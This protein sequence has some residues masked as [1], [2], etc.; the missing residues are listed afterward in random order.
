MNRQPPCSDEDL[1]R[2]VDEELSDGERARM[3]DLLERNPQVADRVQ[4]HRMV[5]DLVRQAFEEIETAARPLAPEHRRHTIPRIAAAAALFVPLGFLAGWLA[6]P[7]LPDRGEPTLL[8]GGVSLE[9]TSGRLTHALFHIDA[10]DPAAMEKLLERAESILARS[11]DADAQ[12]EVVANAG[13]L[14]LLR[15]DTSAYAERLRNLMARYP[16]LTIVACANAI[17]RF[18]ERGT[19]VLLFSE[20]KSD[21]TA[22]DHIVQRLQQGWTYIKL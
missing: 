9:R 6:K 22:I 20:V 14:N 21:E 10:D 13:G 11:G 8:A 5:D 12:V 3:A 7:A 15:A 2:F 4:R 19:N 18:E 16:N 17:K 1:H